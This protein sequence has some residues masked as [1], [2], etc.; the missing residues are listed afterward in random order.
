MPEWINSITFVI[1]NYKKCVFRNNSIKKY[2]CALNLYTHFN[3][4][5]AKETKQPC[6]PVVAALITGIF[7]IGTVLI[8][9]TAKPAFFCSVAFV[10]Q[11]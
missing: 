5:H 3:Q 8:L 9:P 7:L 11:Q 10:R 6:C 1:I 4:E 2:S